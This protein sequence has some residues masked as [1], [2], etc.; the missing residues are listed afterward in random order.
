MRNISD[1]ICRENKN[2]PFMFNKYFSENRAVFEILWK[3][4][5]ELHRTNMTI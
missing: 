3:N 5:V 1:K 2:T 4:I